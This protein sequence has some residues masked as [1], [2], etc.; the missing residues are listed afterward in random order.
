MP[1][2]IRRYARIGTIK[3]K[4]EVERERINRMMVQW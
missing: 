3:R 1:R 4:Y 2:R